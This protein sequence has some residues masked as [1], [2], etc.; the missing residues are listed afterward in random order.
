MWEPR[1]LFQTLEVKDLTTHCAFLRGVG[2][3]MNP[4][5]QD[6]WN[7]LQSDDMTHEGFHHPLADAQDIDENLFDRIGTALTISYGQASGH[8]KADLFST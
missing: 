1:K 5:A 7:W 4:D 3:Q 6:A 2:Q 8:I